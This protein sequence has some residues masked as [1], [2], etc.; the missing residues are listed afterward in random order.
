MPKAVQVFE[1]TRYNDMARCKKTLKTQ[2]SASTFSAMLNACNCKAF[3]NE[4]RVPTVKIS[5]LSTIEEKSTDFYGGTS[6][7]AV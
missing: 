7:C 5:T 6:F 4:K 1:N 3:K 2:I